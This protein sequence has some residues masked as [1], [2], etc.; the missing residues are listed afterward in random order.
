MERVKYLFDKLVKYCKFKVIDLNKCFVEGIEPRRGRPKDNSISE[1]DKE[2][3]AEK[4]IENELNR[5]EEQNIKEEIAN[6]INHDRMEYYPSDKYYQTINNNYNTNSM[7]LMG[8][9]LSGNYAPYR[10]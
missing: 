8:S 9:H 6:K 5:L 3:N 10:T 7:F 4:E 2:E 1:Y